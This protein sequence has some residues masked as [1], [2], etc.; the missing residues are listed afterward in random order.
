MAFNTA[1]TRVPV[2]IGGALY[3]GSTGT[4][5]DADDVW[6]DGEIS[7]DGGTTKWDLGAATSGSKL[8]NWYVRVTI[9]GQ[10]FDLLAYSAA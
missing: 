5:P 3:V 4:D 8:N 6:C 7:T 1:L 10:N 2:R 9:G